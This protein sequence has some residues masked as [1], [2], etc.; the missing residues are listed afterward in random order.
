MGL[1]REAGPMSGAGEQ[2]RGQCVG[3]AREAGP[4]LEPER[5]KAAEPGLATRY[6]AEVK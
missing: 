1:V 5:E 4:M 2:R 6:G 3:L